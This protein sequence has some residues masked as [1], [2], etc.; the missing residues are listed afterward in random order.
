[1]ISSNA[2]KTIE[3]LE[4]HPLVVLT[5]YNPREGMTLRQAAERAGKSETT[6][7]NWATN[8]GLG[9]RVGGGVWIISRPALE[10][11]LDGDGK[12]LLLYHQGKCDMLE[13]RVYFERT[14]VPCRRIAAFPE[15]SQD[16]V[17]TTYSTMSATSTGTA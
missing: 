13:V 3:T 16:L 17:E 14:R 2:T 10:M 11:F 4:Q 1:M 6:I 7:K 8:K 9:R 15:H 5:P 12:A